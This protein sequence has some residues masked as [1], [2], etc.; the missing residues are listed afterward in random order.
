M[1]VGVMKTTSTDEKRRLNHTYTHTAATR[2][3]LNTKQ[4]RWR[5]RHYSVWEVCRSRR[6][7]MCW[8][9][10]FMCSSSATTI[11]WHRTRVSWNSRGLSPPSSRLSLVRY[12]FAHSAQLRRQKFALRKC[13]TFIWPSWGNFPRDSGCVVGGW[14]SDV[15]SAFSG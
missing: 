3:D 4:L 5:W 1:L 7:S 13:S 12:T 15:M 9:T 10:T 11:W 14:K 6:R 2:R 8:W